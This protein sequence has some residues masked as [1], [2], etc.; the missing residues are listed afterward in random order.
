MNSTDTERP[1]RDGRPQ[2]T[3]RPPQRPHVDAASAQFFGRPDGV[4]GSF[5][6]GA[7]GDAPEKSG[8]TLAPPDPVLR[9]A[10]SRPPGE[11]DTLQRDPH[12]APGQQEETRPEDPWRDPAAVVRLG[13]AA[14]PE[15][16]APDPAPG[17]RLGAREVLFGGKVSPK[18][19]AAL[20]CFALAI[21]LVGGLVGGLVSKAHSALTDDS[22][23]EINLAGSPPAPNAEAVQKVAAAVAPA[24]VTI[25]SVYTQGGDKVKETGSG[26]VIAGDG[27]IVTNN[28]VV[29]SAA[30]PENNAKLDVIFADGRRMPA[31][32]VGRDPKSDIAVVKVDAKLDK[33]LEFV[34]PKDVHIGEEVVAFGAPFGLSKTVTSGIVSALHRAIVLPSKDSPDDVAASSVIDAVQTDAAINHGNSGGPLVDLNGKIVGINTMI[35]S[36]NDNGSI[37]LGFAIPSNDAQS[38]VNQLIKT[39]SVEHPVIGVSARPV[40]N[41]QG[42]GVAVADVK[43]GGPAD[44]GGIKQGD[45]IVQIGDRPVT[46]LDEFLVGVRK[47]PLGKAT[48]V[49]VL[50]G[51][52]QNKPV[53]LQVTPDSDKQK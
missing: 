31:K 24:V 17:R 10:F 40:V 36:P 23:P 39:G 50:R 37:G 11:T 5:L 6:P 47:M 4:Q 3:P 46:S 13:G 9:E 41:D 35:F 32:I 21:A 28:H 22:H 38:E 33:T 19:L 18:A 49:K 20:G 14:Y 52:G 26:A 53:E 25:E 29:E 7:A 27:Y 48:T 1:L 2:Y 43:P 42:S 34:N 51:E 15:P 45:V 44:R 30:V 8:Y 16:T 12:S